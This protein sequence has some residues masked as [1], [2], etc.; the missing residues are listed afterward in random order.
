LDY[1]NAKANNAGFGKGNSG[2]ATYGFYKSYRA[3][4]INVF[5]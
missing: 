5:T 1:L 2:F 4:S 3:Y